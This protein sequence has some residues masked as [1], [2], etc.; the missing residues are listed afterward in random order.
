MKKILGIIASKRR[1]GN[2]EIMVKEIGRQISVP[3]VL[4]LLRLPDFHLGYCTGC[5]RCLTRDGGCVLKDDL[6]RILEAI[7]GAD[8]VILAVP[9]YVLSAPAC[10]KSLLDRAVSFYGVGEGLWGKPAVGIGIAGRVGKEGSTL[11]DM[12]R[13]F[14]VF[15]M[16]NQLSRIVY[17]ALP[18]EALLPD[19]NREVARAIADALSGAAQARGEGR[20]ETSCRLCGGETFRFLGGDRVRCMLCSATGTVTML[21]N[22]PAIDMDAE[23]HQF[24]VGKEEAYEHRNSLNSIRERFEAQ[25][26]RLKEVVAG[27]ADEGTWLRPEGS[28]QSFGRKW[29]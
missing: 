28:R 29:S 27:Y 4:Q 13:F 7:A 11:L 22:R 15:Q 5:F 17:G 1:L 21:N 26:V 10:L 16:K 12:E 20:G 18:G 6:P 2:C 3:H 25:K 19:E 8:A 9:T 14:A 23:E 24:L